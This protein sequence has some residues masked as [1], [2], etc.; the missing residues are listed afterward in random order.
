MAFEKSRRVLTSQWGFVESDYVVS[1]GAIPLITTVASADSVVSPTVTP[2]GSMGSVAMFAGPPGVGKS[3]AAEAVGYETG[4]P[5]KVLSCPEIISLRGSALTSRNG[6]LHT[7]FSVLSSSALWLP[8]QVRSLSC[9][10]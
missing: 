9:L 7:M 5:L 1:F 4:R 3:L 10:C 2:Q 8:A 6:A